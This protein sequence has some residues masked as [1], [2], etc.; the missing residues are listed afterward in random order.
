MGTERLL[1]EHQLSPRLIG[2]WREKHMNIQDRYLEYAD[3]FEKTYIDNDWSRL[4]EYF[5][6]DA[7]Y[8]SGDGT[9]AEGRSAVLAKL[10][11]AVDGLDRLMD[12]RTLDFNP[13]STEG[14]TVSIEWTVRY[15][16]AGV[17]DLKIGGLEFARFEGDRIA[18]LW[19]ELEP[20][21][22]EIIGEW[23]TVHGDKLSS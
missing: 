8:D 12:S 10:E 18:H 14:N 17:P 6:D 9:P 2:N 1:M 16:K 19:D 20:G 11:A 21:A 13:P 4:T 3:A 7:I 23:M 5:T 22:V 15:T